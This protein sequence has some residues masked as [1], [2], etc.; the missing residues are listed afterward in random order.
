MALRCLPLWLSG[1]TLGETRVGEDPPSSPGMAFLGPPHSLHLWPLFLFLSSPPPPPPGVRGRTRGI[2]P[3]G[4]LVCGP[5]PRHVARWPDAAAGDPPEAWHQRAPSGPGRGDCPLGACRC[6][7]TFEESGW[8]QA[9]LPPPAL[10]ALVL[11][12][13]SPGGCFAGTGLRGRLACGTV[14]RATPRELQTRGILFSSFPEPPPTSWL[15]QCGARSHGSEGAVARRPPPPRAR[16]Q[17]GAEGSGGREAR[18]IFYG[19]P[20][21]A[22][23]GTPVGAPLRRPT[24]DDADPR[25][26]GALE[27]VRPD[28]WTLAR[29]ALLL[30]GWTPGC[31]LAGVLCAGLPVA[32]CRSF[33]VL[34]SRLPG[35]WL[36]SLTCWL[37]GYPSVRLPWCRCLRTPPRPYGSRLAPPACRASRAC[38]ARSPPPG[39]TGVL[40]APLAPLGGAPSD[41]K[42]TPLALTS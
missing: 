32:S 5:I 4:R 42:E 26:R 23:A 11:R 27:K 35:P 34:T 24:K 25:A 6:P 29:L 39:P 22:R 9:P 14:P 7:G 20:R 10:L 31:L 30:P 36:P 33:Q 21:H 16:R 12:R 8:R 17:R 2:V 19:G 41:A 40:L 37:L 18:W 1:F 13:M 28:R 15:T 38:R 3:H